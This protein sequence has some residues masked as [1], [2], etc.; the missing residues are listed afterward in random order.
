MT[1]SKILEVHNLIELLKSDL[2]LSTGALS[3]SFFDHSLTETF[4]VVA[5]NP[6]DVLLS[7]VPF[8]IPIEVVENLPD[9]FLG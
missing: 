5:C 2:F 7:D 4:V 8:P 1:H 9:L 3:H 6:L